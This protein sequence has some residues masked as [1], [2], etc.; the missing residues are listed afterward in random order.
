[1]FLGYIYIYIYSCIYSIVSAHC[2][3]NVILRVQS[4]VYFYISTFLSMCAVPN[5]AVFSSSLFSFCFRTLF[6]YYYYYY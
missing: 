6:R 5:M 4:C 1:M 3:C 2:T